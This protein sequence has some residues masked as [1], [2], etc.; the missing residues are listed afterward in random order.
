MDPASA[1]SLATA[2]LQF[3]EFGANVCGRIHEVASSAIGLTKENAH[4]HLTVEE[5]RNVTGG[6]ITN[7]NGNTKHEAELVKL[8]G[9][10]R[11]LSAELTELDEAF[12]LVDNLQPNLE[13]LCIYGLK[14]A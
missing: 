3:V 9:Q 2:I 6:L 10:C 11:D 12:F 14:R 13:A 8:A 7:I 4:S 5:L 1:I